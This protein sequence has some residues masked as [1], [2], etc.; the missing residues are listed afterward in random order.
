MTDSSVELAVI[1]EDNALKGYCCLRQC[2]DSTE[3]VGG[4][5]ENFG[6]LQAM[7]GFLQI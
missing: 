2:L 4:F 7:F 5:K 6:I 1:D 3:R